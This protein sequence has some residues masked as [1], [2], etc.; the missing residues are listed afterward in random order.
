[1]LVDDELAD[2]EMSSVVQSLRQDPE[3]QACWR[4]YHLIGDAMRGGL[5]PHV[6]VD[7]SD[8]IKDALQHEPVFL[9]PSTTTP[10]THT[11]T[12]HRSKGTIGF[13][14]AA[15]LTAIAV[16][17]VVGIDQE[18]GLQNPSA[19]LVANSG[20]TAA[21]E[22]VPALSSL[23][24]ELEASGTTQGEGQWAR[25]QTVSGA[26]ALADNAPD[27]YEYLVNYQQYAVRDGRDDP[28]SYL[29]VVSHGSSQ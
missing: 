27:L 1:M 9:H 22:A 28:L 17:G 14:L 6:C 13:A 3:M 7:L 23:F 12:H 5:P 20:I 18:Q 24:A 19:A 4:N 21:H 15:S 26:G 11:G 8:R 2:W 25:I 10:P 16:F 29:R